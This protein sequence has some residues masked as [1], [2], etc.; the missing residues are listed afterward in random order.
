M[1]H[2]RGNSYI[3]LH[4]FYETFGEYLFGSLSKAYDHLESITN[5]FDIFLAIDQNICIQV[6][7]LYPDAEMPRFDVSLIDEDN[8]KMLYLS[9]GKWETC[10]WV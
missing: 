10:R 5:S 3:P 7:M 1:Y 6:K 8:L 4:A 2:L 9:E